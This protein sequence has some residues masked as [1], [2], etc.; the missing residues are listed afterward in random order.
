QSRGEEIGSHR[1][2]VRSAVDSRERGWGLGTP[3]A[4]MEGRPP[5]ADDD[6]RGGEEGRSSSSSS[7]SDLA[8][9]PPQEAADALFR[10]SEILA[11]MVR[12]STTPL[13]TLALSR[14]ASLTYTEE[15]VDR[16]VLPTERIVNDELGTIDYRVPRSSYS[17]KVQRRLDGDKDNPDARNGAVILRIDP[18]VEK[19]KL[20]Y[21]M[22]TGE[23]GLAL[24]AAHKVVG[25]VSGI[26]VNMGCPKKFSVSGGMGSALLSDPR[27]ACDIISTLRRNLTKPVSAKIRL[28][29]PADP[30]P[31]LDFVRAL[32]RAGANAIAIHGRI[33][34]DESHVAARWTT[35]AEVVKELKRT[36]TV[37]IIINGD[38]YTRADIREMKRRT[39]CDGIMLARPA[40]Y[41]VSLFR[42]GEEETG[43]DS[44]TSD[45][46]NGEEEVPLTQFQGRDHSGRYGYRSPLLEPRTKIVQD[47]VAHCVRYKAHSK[48][49]KYVVCEMMNGRRAPTGRVS[50]LDVGFAGGQTIQTVCKCR[51]LDDL[52]RVWDVRWSVPMPGAS[53][54]GASGEREEKPSEGAGDLRDYDDRYFLAPDEFRRQRKAAAAAAGSL[55]AKFVGDE[56]K[57]EEGDEEVVEPATKRVKS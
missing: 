14:G 34:G 20:V 11:P 18:K 44:P 53:S 54:A 13:R 45:D 9:L 49:A 4:A 36:E 5:P 19:D 30:R 26:D 28:L 40:L 27:R 48:N 3:V 21:Q 7:S 32:I 33:V 24:R 52:V 23:S 51:S 35:L 56:K 47:Y 31:T 55:D 46:S 15:L 43:G 22:G 16:S 17:S 39:G 41:N 10:S 37:P 25:D 50:F 38:L 8:S 42:R 6:D 57:A 1:E 29:D 12:A 2:S